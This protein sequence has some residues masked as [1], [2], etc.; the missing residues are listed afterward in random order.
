[1]DSRRGAVG[2]AVSDLR[3][4]LVWRGVLVRHD[5]AVGCS[6]LQPVVTPEDSE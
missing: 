6:G 5:G 2:P 3:G 4:V 1:V